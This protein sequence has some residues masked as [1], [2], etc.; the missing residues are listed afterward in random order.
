MYY[1]RICWWNVGREEFQAKQKGGGTTN[2]EKLRTK[3]FN[4]VK[5]SRAVRDKLKK[6]LKS[7]QND[8]NKRVKSMAKQSKKLNRRRL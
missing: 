7:K 2:R 8:I 3:N 6:T 5:K 4:M 1:A